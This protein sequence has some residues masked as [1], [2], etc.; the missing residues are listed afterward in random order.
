M[1]QKLVLASVLFLL[2]LHADSQTIQLIL[3]PNPSP[4]ISDWESRTETASLIIN[5]PTNEDIRVKVRAV[6]LNGK[7]EIVAQTINSKM[8]ILNIP[9]GVS[10][11][12]AEDI[13][14][15]HALDYQGDLERTT[16]QTGRVPDDNY[17]FCVSLIDPDTHEPVGPSGEVCRIFSILDYQA[18]VLLTP[19]DLE[20]IPP[21]DAFG[22][23]FRWTPVMPSPRG[24]VTYRL[25]IFELL[26]GQENAFIAL[27]NNQ[28]IVEKDYKGITQTQWPVEFAPP[29]PGR[30]YVWTVTPLDD[31]DRKIVD[32]Y[33]FAEPFSFT[34]GFILR[35]QGEEVGTVQSGETI[36]AGEN[37]EFSIEV[38]EVTAAADG[39]LTGK[40]KAHINWL[41]VAVAV[42][43]TN[44]K[45]DNA[46]QL[47]HGVITAMQGGS[48]GSAWY[49]YPKAWGMAFL[50]TPWVVGLADGVV[51]WT[52]DQ[53]N[54]IVNGI[55]DNTL[56][57]SQ[58]VLHYNSNITAPAIP[59]NSLK[60]PFGLQFPINGN[61]QKL[62][63]TE[64]VFKPDESKI[65]FLAQSEFAKSGQLYELGFVG[66]YFK[67]HP[68][69]IEF[70]NG[71]VELAADFTIPSPKMD[72]ILKK[73]TSSAGC[74]IQWSDNG[75]DQIGL[76][77]DVSFSREWLI[78]I[79]SNT[80]TEKVKATLSGNGT[81][82]Q[83]ILLTG[84]FPK[85]E[86][87]GTNGLKIEASNI[88]F[89]L[90]DIRSIPA[91]IF[92]TNY[93]GSTDVTWRGFYMK[94]FGIT[95]P[96]S[97][98]T[99]SNTSP[100]SLAAS[101]L[102]IDDL[103]ITTKIRGLNLL[104]LQS[105]RVADLSASLDTVEVAI[106]HSSL[107]SGSVK[108]KLVL[109]ISEV[110]AQNTLKYKAT[111]SQASTGG[112]FQIVIVPTQPIEASIMRGSM[113]LKPTSNITATL[114]SGSITA[115]ITLNGVFKWNKPNL[116][117][118]AS[119]STGN[120]TPT[121]TGGIEGI[122]IELGFENVNFTYTRNTT[123][124]TND[125]DFNLGNWSFASP[126]KFLANFPV[127]I[128]KIYYKSLATESS[129]EL[130]RGALMIDIVAN[131]TE[132]IG[133]STT[134]GAVFAVDFDMSQIKFTPHFK[135]VFIE[136][137]SIYANL[138]AV[139]IEGSI[140]FR[141]NDPV[142][143]DG[144]KGQ[145]T[146]AFT[147]IGVS[148]SALVEFG[149]TN[150]LNGNALYRYWRVEA[151][152][153]LP[154]PGIPFLTGIAFRGFGGGAYYNMQATWTTSS[155]NP[156]GNKFTFTPKKSTLGLSISATIA[157]TPKEE[158]FNA[159][160]KLT[161]EFSK[162]QGL[163]FISFTGSFY[164]ASGLTAPQRAKAKVN[165]SVNVTY[166]FPD[167]HFMLS[168]SVMVNAPPITTPYA[169]NLVLDI[170]GKTNKWFF[171]FGEPLP[172]QYV[173]VNVF[174]VSLYQYLMFGNSITIP[175]G[176][177]QKFKDG[178]YGVFHE[179]PGM[180]VTT[181]G[182][183]SPNTATGKGMALGIGFNFN[184]DLN[185][186]IVGN[187]DASLSL[188]AG[189]E[190]N[191]SFAE[192]LGQN[193]ENPS[194]RIGINGWQ[195]AGDIGFYAKVLAY[196]K[197]T[198]NNNT[199]PLADI[200]AGGWLSGRFPN[201]VYVQGA[202]Q[203]LVKIGHFTTPQHPLG[204]AC[205]WLCWEACSHNNDH[206]LVNTSFNKNFNYGSNCSGISSAGSSGT[207]VQ[208]DAAEDQSQLLIKYIHPDQRY[209]FP[210]SAPLAVKF[211]LMPDKVF[212]VAEQQ[213]DGSVK[214]RTFKM[215]I[216][217]SLQ[218][219]NDDGSLTNQMTKTAENNLGEYLFIVPRSIDFNNMLANTNLAFQP[220]ITNISSST[221]NS[222]PPI[223]NTITLSYPLAIP[224]NSYSNLP[225]S[226]PELK[227]YLTVNKNY[228]FTISATLKE[229]VNS[230]WVDARN[231]SNV[232]VSQ[233]VTKHFRTGPQFV[234]SNITDTPSKL[235]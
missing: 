187:Y 97:W 101:D 91:I 138:S 106:L 73:G 113:T 156:S 86:I 13:F 109:P 170:N 124:Q 83:D 189:A 24:I 173:A 118:T 103:G 186:N 57:F 132:D 231:N 90:S 228:K 213:S 222:T 112:T 179:Y 147:S 233:T 201:P 161:A 95:M 61:D 220:N 178:Y 117:V 38:S 76:E 215:V 99:G 37:G 203:G 123:A 229:Y 6:L 171:K 176:F 130:L 68:G 98:K 172:N 58:P 3:S 166:N 188:G 121:R 87:V 212:D 127:T 217:Y 218:L 226:P 43:F 110:T 155:T 75:I 42:E 125:F 140:T 128:D 122:E 159:D 134:V 2:S 139:K 129:A 167:K 144:F 59:D 102:I 227:N 19:V 17:Q 194:E 162:A 119:S 175:S 77:L 84:N 46:N 71:R 45:I 23:M 157:T 230:A 48:S 116:G 15:A 41:G 182:A 70:S 89:D 131:L 54:N 66:K 60:M 184:K 210:T 8:N 207:A 9:P 223:L 169:A 52:N 80:P 56:G 39:S 164:V 208:G 4:Y 185:F 11:Y 190:L 40:G 137:I 29:E 78:P 26:E 5:N 47:T 180:S 168:A 49:D 148:A 50:S 74:Y 199:W 133:G 135:G 219:V 94:T 232:L 16:A 120:T 34:V 12:N 30:S 211:G 7:G 146:V 192:Y 108:G 27:S 20:V 55:I 114:A 152:V 142:F 14:P 160:V 153:M 111:F 163:I 44:I 104:N 63:I 165:G 197:K 183:T 21:S 22:I 154:P 33:G 158:T 1:I 149:N 200:R 221:N 53:V 25:Q 143:G 206:Y 100:P 216:A 136:T 28:P 82:M 214:L 67:I 191:L 209:N 69:N 115:A 105:G 198:T 126:Q 64:I 234:I 224:N 193:C 141:N 235:N 174:N 204:H 10:Q 150:Y 93:P 18:P 85:S 196:V 195:A 31:E 88:A 35:T 51:N 225:P 79:P 202:V 181:A 32:G 62:I 65:N 96:E 81:N 151:D 205:G 107:Q 177:T 145:L 72:F 92:P 36:T